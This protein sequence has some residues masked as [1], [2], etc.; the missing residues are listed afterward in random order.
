MD[1]VSEEF[2]GD[3]LINLLDDMKRLSG[4]G[5]AN[6]H[7][8]RTYVIDDFGKLYYFAIVRDDSMWSDADTDLQKALDNSL[9][10]IRNNFDAC[11]L[12]SSSP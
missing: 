1:K 7:D 6:V 8:C 4:L 9:D 5:I 11:A 12:R 10:N 2:D 3:S